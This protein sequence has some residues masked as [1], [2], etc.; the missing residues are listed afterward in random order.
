MPFHL[1]SP[2]FADGCPIL[3][4]YTRDG[5]NP[6]SALESSDSPDRTPSFAPVMVRT[7]GRTASKGCWSAKL[8]GCRIGGRAQKEIRLC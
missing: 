6:S 7:E 3:K 5:H 2:A 1:T 8:E 4:Q